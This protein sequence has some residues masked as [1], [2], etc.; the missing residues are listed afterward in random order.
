MK[1]VRELVEAGR[2]LRSKIGIKIRYP[3]KNATI[4]SNKKVKDSIINIIDL[5]NEEIN[6]KN[7]S[8]EKDSS[9]FLIKTVK[10]NQSVIGPK[11]KDNAR[12]IAEKIE[13]MDAHKLYKKLKNNGKIELKIKIGKITLKDKDFV[14]V[15]KEKEDY[16]KTK[17]ENVVLFLNKKLTPELKAEGFARE[18]VR[19]IQSMRK[20]LDL[21]VEDKI[22]T[23]IKIEKGDIEALK[24][25]EDY[26]KTETRS[27]NIE[28]VDRPS[29]SLVKKWNIDNAEIEIGIEK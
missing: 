7:F 15:E 19:R 24:D 13:N 10:P 9:K 26:I 23:Q 28:Y 17:V 2:A 6:V 12:E 1:K 8:F 29:G 27:K 21:D 18:I 4:I 16:A 14:E 25:W 3:L 20:E 22:S 5:L 11:Y